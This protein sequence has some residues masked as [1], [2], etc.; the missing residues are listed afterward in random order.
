MILLIFI[1]AIIRKSYL[2]RKYSKTF[3]GKLSKNYEKI[4]ETVHRFGRGG[5]IT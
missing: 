4:R 1:C 2:N 5:M 3:V